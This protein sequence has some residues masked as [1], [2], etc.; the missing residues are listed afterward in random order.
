MDIPQNTYDGKTIQVTGCMET[1]EKGAVVPGIGVLYVAY[2]IT[3]E[4]ALTPLVTEPA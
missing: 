4:E 2:L 1:E 3:V